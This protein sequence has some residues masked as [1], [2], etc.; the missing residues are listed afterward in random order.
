MEWYESDLGRYVLER[1]LDWFDAVSSDLFGFHAVQIGDCAIDY[2]RANRMPQRFCLCPREG[3]VRGQPES[4]PIAGQSLDLVALPHVLEF[5]SNPHQ[6]LREAER[7]LR[8]EG[9][10]LIAGFNPLSLWGLRRVGGSREAPGPWEGRFIHLARIKDWLALLG[11]ELAGG[12]MACYAPPINRSRWLSGF[13][14]LEAAGDRW[15]ALGGGVYLLHAVKRVHGMRL[16]APKWDSSWRSRPAWAQS[17]TTSIQKS[18]R[19]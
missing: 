18:K 4:L 3:V 7:V 19:P 8:P 12:R 11:F 17:T 16:I 9:R 5:S 6:V 10:L 15:W 13:G 14:F 2:L 1:E